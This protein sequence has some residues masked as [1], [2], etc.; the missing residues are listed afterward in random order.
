[1]LLEIAAYT[2]ASLKAGLR[3]APYISSR[4]ASAVKSLYSSHTA[5]NPLRTAGMSREVVGAMR[6]TSL[7]VDIAVGL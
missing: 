1:M 2:S 5:C 6:E 3:N 7:L 4:A